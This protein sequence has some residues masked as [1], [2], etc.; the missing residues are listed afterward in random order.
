MNEIRFD[1]QQ[2]DERILYEAH[3]DRRAVLLSVLSVILAAAFLMLITLVMAIFL[4]EFRAPILLAG[5]LIS[6]ILGVAAWLTSLFQLQRNVAYITD[7]RVIRFSSV[8]PWSTSSRA[9]FWDEVVKIK[10]KAPS[11]LYKVMNVGNVVAHA[12]TEGDDLDITNISY[13]KDLGNYMDKVMYLYKKEPEKLKG[14]R[15]FVPK[16]KGQRY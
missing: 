9:L 4:P 5:L 13:F 15:S 1:G 16:P 12:R 8:G 11:W 6:A 7:R 2:E 3:P 10:T 14:I